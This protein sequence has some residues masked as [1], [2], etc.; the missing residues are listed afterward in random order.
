MGLTT[1][2]AGGHLFVLCVDEDPRKKLSF[3]FQIK[4]K[5]LLTC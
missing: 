5:F 3:N 1:T 2:F 4:N